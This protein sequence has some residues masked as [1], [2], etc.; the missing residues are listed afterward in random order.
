MIIFLI[1]ITHSHPQH[2]ILSACFTHLLSHAQHFKCSLANIHLSWPSHPVPL[3]CKPQCHI[4]SWS[5]PNSSML[6]GEKKL[7]K[8]VDWSHLKSWTE[9]GTNIRVVTNTA[10]QTFFMSPV[11]VQSHCWRNQLWVVFRSVLSESLHC[12]HSYNCWEKVEVE[13]TMSLWF[14][15]FFIWIIVCHDANGTKKKSPGLCKMNSKSFRSTLVF[16]LM[17]QPVFLSNP[18]VAVLRDQVPN[19]EKTWTTTWYLWHKKYIFGVCLISWH[20]ESLK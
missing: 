7:Y 18:N 20:L 11:N 5:P 17:H 8:H 10:K 12:W 16:I 4:N 3:T 15:F 2:H 1:S 19:S 6:L 14:I 9:V 13:H